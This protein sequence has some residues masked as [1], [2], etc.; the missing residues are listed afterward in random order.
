MYKR[1]KKGN[2][3]ITQVELNVL[4]INSYLYDEMIKI[5]NQ[6]HSAIGIVQQL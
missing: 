2:Y 5:S 6:F 1:P 4:L 3:E